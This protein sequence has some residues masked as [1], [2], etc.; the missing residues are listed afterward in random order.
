VKDPANSV[1]SFAATVLRQPL[2]PHQVEA[3]ESRAFITSI[4]AARRTG[5]TV[6]AET[7]AVWTAMRERN[8]MVL[9]LSATQEASRRLT[10]S[11][12]ATLNA[13]ELTRGA[14]VD[15]LTTRIRLTNGSQIISLPASQRQIR[16][17]GRGV[18]LV[19]LDEAGFMPQELWPA[20][21]YCALDERPHSRILLLG[22][23][24]GSADA[25]FRR[26]FI[27]GQTDDPDHASFQW[28][29]E[30]NPNLDHK[31]LERQRERV[32][33]QEYAAEILGQW[34]NAAGAMFT[35]ELLESVTADVDIPALHALRGPAR[36]VV[37][38]DYGISHDLSAVVAIFRLPVRAL[39]PDTDLRPTF[40]AWPY[41]WPQG[42]KLHNV[43]GDIVRAAPN[44]ACLSTETNGIGGM[45]SQELLRGCRATH[46][47]TKFLWNFV[48]TT[49][50]SKT[51]GYGVLLNLMERQQLVLP[52]HPNLL[53][54]L[55]AVRF[56]V[57]ARGVMGIDTEDVSRDD[58]AD[59]AYLATLPY[60]PPG[61]HRV[62]CRL[63]TLAG[64]SAGPEERTPELDCPVVTTGAGL[65]VYQ[66]P[67][68]QG[69]LSRSTGLSL[70]AP[71]V[72][73]KPEGIQAGR[74]FFNTSRKGV[75]Q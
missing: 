39:N 45:P 64:D 59:S 72:P 51:T 21:H 17:Y 8:V 41:T 68:L 32:S 35:R 7:L 13:R 47:S 73:P 75:M 30:A 5:K 22:T 27:A 28:R 65:L 37:G 15:D 63:A 44:F 69:V 19:V 29:Y 24:W 25:F 71:Q 54:Q 61:A 34:S 46:P 38:C 40:M 48:N 43:V 1:T 3:A 67:P 9:L 20:A 23:P 16:G 36:G 31:Y 4:A 42:H 50:A 62:V 70:Y 12:A 57:R 58:V 52:R 33:P 60:R 11:I 26:E 56:E 74:F 10:E 2:W 14:V 55:A 53:R 6:L 18:R 66:R 49:A